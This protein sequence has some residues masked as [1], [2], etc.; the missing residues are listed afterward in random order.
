M[1]PSAF[2]EATKV[3][4]APADMGEHECGSLPVWSDGHI[5]TSLWK[6]SLQERLSILFF[7]NVWLSIFSG[8]TQPPV[9]IVGRKNLFKVVINSS[10]E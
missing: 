7:G 8:Q 6:P 4:K 3:L 10:Q 2:P 9:A 1:E 5:C